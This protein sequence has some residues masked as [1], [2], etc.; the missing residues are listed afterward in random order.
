MAN[1]PEA[2]VFPAGDLASIGIAVATR[3]R[4][5]LMDGSALDG[6]EE[7]LFPDLSGLNDGP[8]FTNR[9]GSG[10]NRDATHLVKAGVV[11]ADDMSTGLPH[12]RVIGI[13]PNGELTDYGEEQSTLLITIALDC[14]ANEFMPGTVSGGIDPMTSDQI[15]GSFAWRLLSHYANM[16]A[17]GFTDARVSTEP[18][19]G[20]TN[21]DGTPFEFHYPLTVDC[22]IYISK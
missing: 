22:E 17:W 13:R 21:K 16:W 8:D 7:P 11:F 20:V 15:L 14:Y 5:M 1:E 10:R 12:V 2:Y 19:P 4:A 3:F 9:E 6:D 18:P